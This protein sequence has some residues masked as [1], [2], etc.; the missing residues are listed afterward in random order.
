QRV[1]DQRLVD[2]GQHLLRHGLGGRQ[3][4]GAQAADRKDG[5]AYLL[6]H[7]DGRTRAAKRSDIR[8]PY[9]EGRLAGREADLA[10]PRLSTPGAEQE[11]RTKRVTRWQGSGS[12]QDVLRL[13]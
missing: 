10:E 3:E 7:G 5:G 13:V 4:T 12:K 1:L 2:H 9:Q 8:A 6:C 11:A